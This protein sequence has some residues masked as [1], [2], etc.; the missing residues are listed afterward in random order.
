MSSDSA[1]LPQS[2]NPDLAPR[3]PGGV[4]IVLAMLLGAAAFAWAGFLG[5]PDEENIFIRDPWLLFLWLCFLMIVAELIIIQTAYQD[6]ADAR[7][8]RWALLTVTCISILIVVIVRLSRGHG[9]WEALLKLLGLDKIGETLRE[10]LQLTL[11]FINLLIILLAWA[12][13]WGARLLRARKSQLHNE[14]SGEQ[15]AG[16]FL[17]GIV[18]SWLLA[19]F[20]IADILQHIMGDKNVSACDALWIPDAFRQALQLSPSACV[21]GGGPW[22]DTTIFFFDLVL[23]P[24]F[25]LMLALGAVLFTSVLRA[26]NRGTLGAFIET[27]PEVINGVRKR[28]TWPIL[29]MQLRIFWP[30]LILGAVVAAALSAAFIQELLYHLNQTWHSCNV[31]LLPHFEENPCGLPFNHNGTIIWLDAVWLNY[32]SRLVALGAAAIALVATI[33]A[34]MLRVYSP[35][36][37]LSAGW[38][39]ATLERVSLLGGVLVFSYWM[40]SLILSLGNQVGVWVIH[41]LWG[42]SDTAKQLLW[43]SFIQPDPIAIASLAIFLAFLIQTWRRSRATASARENAP[44]PAA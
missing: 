11:F 18:G 35:D 37:A 32:R 33:V 5:N 13:L 34:V 44:T 4:A 6:R 27:F 1:P 20:F 15:V 23:Q 25:Y 3:R 9:I 26:L 28:L 10:H 40:F 36:R 7:G 14:I 29:A 8:P 30:V 21:A 43:V 2:A 16:D 42:E 24:A 38:Q 39:R 19:P 22:Q 12:A 31:A 17:I 41:A